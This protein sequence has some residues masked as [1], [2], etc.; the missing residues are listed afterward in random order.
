MKVSTVKNKPLAWFIFMLCG[1]AILWH[2]YHR[3]LALPKAKHT[4]FQ[5]PAPVSAPAYTPLVSELEMPPSA[6]SVHA[7]TLALIKTPQ[8]PQG[9]LMAAW[10]AGSRE[11]HSDVQIYASFLQ[12]MSGQPEKWSD[13]VAILN[14][15]NLAKQ[16]QM[17]IKKLGNPVLYQTA[18]GTI[19]LFVVATS[20]GGWAAAKIAHL[21][22][23]D[24]QAFKLKQILPLSPL[25]N[26]S[27][28]VRTLPVPLADG[29]FYLPIYHELV[30]KFEVVLRFNQHGEWVGKIRPNHLTGTLQPAM[31]ATSPDSC[32]MVRRHHPAQNLLVQTCHAGGLQW[33]KSVVSNISN[34]DNS[35]NIVQFNQKTYL[36]HNQAHDGNH[37]A[38]LWLSELHPVGNAYTVDKQLLLAEMN[39]REVS[40]PSALVVDD[41][42]HVV[43]TQDRVAI[44]HLQI[45]IAAMNKVAGCYRAV[46]SGSLKRI[47]CEQGETS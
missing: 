9:Q 5:L 20:Y 6:K 13:P 22:S 30:N 33:G 44:R 21:T 10:F 19:H 27:H 28:L 23:N 41:N 1:M 46:V 42:L 18:D 3:V 34:E 4:S 31:V 11:G 24:G 25:T 45:N 43:Y 7:A 36:I 12:T 2:G 26:V 47:L 8:H 37:R 40:Y 38:Q 32:L 16:S 14:R 29:G 17:F 39:G 15:D 35:L